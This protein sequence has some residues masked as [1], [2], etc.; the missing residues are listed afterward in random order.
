M[1]ALN[2]KK[3]SLQRAE[4]SSAERYCSVSFP[5]RLHC[6]FEFFF[7]DSRMNV[8]GQV[9]GEDVSRGNVIY[10]ALQRQR[11]NVYFVR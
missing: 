4:L 11:G 3:E 7:C 2:R 10:A 9:I 1:H 8:S 6:Y 5:C